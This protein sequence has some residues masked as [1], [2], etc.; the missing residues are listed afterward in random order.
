M[1][2]HSVFWSFVWVVFVLDAVTAAAPT[3]K[4][5]LEQAGITAFF[6]GDPGYADASAS[7]N[8]RF[9]YQPA[10]IAYATSTAQVSRA[11]RAGVAHDLNVV[12]RSGGHS[13][14]ANGLGGRNGALVVDLSGMKGK[15]Y[16][17]ATGT[18]VIQ[19]GNRIGDIA[20]FLNEYGR[21]MPHG[22]CAYV[23]IGGHSGHGGYG[24]MSRMWGLTLDVVLSATVVLS[25]G[26]IV[27]A[28]NAS[29]A[30]LYWAIRGASA[31]FGIVTEIRV[32]TFQ[33]PQE[34]TFFEYVYSASPS[35][36]A[37][38][39]LSFQAYSY[40]DLP[41]AFAAEVVFFKVDAE[42][43][44][45]VFFGAHYGP[46]SAF[47]RTI[48]PFLD[49]VPVEPSQTVITRG[50]WLTVVNASAF[51][52]GPLNVSSQP[53]THD[54]FYAKS[55]MTPE[56]TPLTPEAINATFAYM[57]SNGVNSSSFQYDI[58]MEFWGGRGSAVNAVPF[59]ATAFAH[60]DVHFTMQLYS[61]VADGAYP[62]EGLAFMDGLAA[63]IVDS[64]PADWGYS[65]YPNY[66]DGRL[67]DWQRL[68]YG[69]H[70]PRLQAIK[71]KYDPHNVFRFPL[72]IEE[73]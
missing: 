12:A 1:K 39:M 16:D 59:D 10:G 9:D 53:D 61:D 13:Y 8:Q 54:T 23:G 62:D 27:T 46:Y 31:S 64:M 60:R 55:I 56:E 18:A 44:T 72:S 47:N 50:D 37:R 52:V 69:S 19:T 2:S 21:G 65:A 36:A 15:T 42:Q 7:Y 40:T 24:Y 34:N 68:Y 49:T 14:I 20:L 48:Q 30:D 58:E 67:Q 17:A 35:D 38:V 70:Y 6:P 45:L 32:Q 22:R 71:R 29:N 11:L 57:A 26:R 5:Q 4:Q 43:F 25:D 66:I 3:L 28:S 33:A 73:Q 41:R 63:S 51:G